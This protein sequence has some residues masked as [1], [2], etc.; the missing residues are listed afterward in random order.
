MERVVSANIWPST[1]PWFNWVAATA[2]LFYQRRMTALNF[3]PYKRLTHILTATLVC[4]IA[5]SC[6]KD[7][8]LMKS[9]RVIMGTYVTITVNREGLT[10]DKAREAVA[11][12]YAEVERVDRLM[13]TYK[14]ESDLSKVNKEAGIRPVKVDP[15]VV[16]CVA[17]ALGI[18]MAT[19]GSFDPTVGPLVRLWGVGSDHAKVPAEYEIRASLARV[20]YRKVVV[21]KPASTVFI[22]DK[23]MGLDLGG[24]AKGYASDLAVAALK[25]R[26][27]KGAIVACAGDIRLFGVREG[28]APWRVGVQH[29]RDKAAL[30]TELDLTDGAVSTSGDYE[31]FFI[32]DGVVYHHIM[33]PRTGGPAR[34]L[35]SV[36]ILAREAW[37]ADSLATGLF[38][39]GPERALAYARAHPEIEVLMVGLDGKLMATGR[40]DKL[41]LPAVVKVGPLGQ[42]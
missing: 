10:D 22:K 8:G 28:G 16:D 31:R 5:A 7:A 30:L 26:G 33:D 3:T 35:V 38:V 32:K 39:L 24:I 12:A 37:L 13:S 17:R 20:D 23:A 41:G 14:P 25:R 29:P 36:T 42:M 18:A 9:T 11:A 1:A 21:D 6:A 40:F 27:V 2:F 4:L 19:D 34:G 15:E